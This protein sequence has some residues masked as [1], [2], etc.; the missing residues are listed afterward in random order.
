MQSE[1]APYFQLFFEKEAYELNIKSTMEEMMVSVN[2]ADPFVLAAKT[3]ASSADNPTWDQAMKGPFAEEYWRAAE[4][5]VETL[6]RIRAWIVV[7]RTA[8]M[9][10]LPGTWAFKCKR[11]PDGKVKKFKARFCARGDRQKE[12]IDFFET[13]AP[14]AQ[15]TT[16]RMMLIL[17]CL[18]GLKS[19]QGDI[20]CAFLHAELE[21]HEKIYVKMP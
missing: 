8:D 21:S 10:V 18:L 11:Y 12:G 16:V 4:L 5:E 14:V 6:E 3:A 15:W 17:E 9:N 7:E 13:Y 1:I 2:Y 20:S 19:K